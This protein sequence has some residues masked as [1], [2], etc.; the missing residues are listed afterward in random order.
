MTCQA[1]EQPIDLPKDIFKRVDLN[2][3][4]VFWNICGVLQEHTK[5]IRTIVMFFL[6]IYAIL[7]FHW[8]CWL[9]ELQHLTRYLQWK[10]DGGMILKL[11]NSLTWYICFN[12]PW[13]LFFGVKYIRETPYTSNS[14]YLN[15]IFLWRRRWII[16]VCSR[17]LNVLVFTNKNIQSI[18]KEQFFSYCCH[19]LTRVLFKLDN[20]LKWNYFGVITII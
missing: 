20:N 1:G 16:R 18:S 17:A 5:D 19:S 7:S 14:R 9:R 4:D 8:K 6:K 2:P 10:R 12:A 15:Y 11:Y 3:L 13:N